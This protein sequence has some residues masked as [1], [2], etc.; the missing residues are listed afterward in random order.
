MSHAKNIKNYYREQEKKKQKETA[1]KRNRILMI[2][3]SVALLIAI[4]LTVVFC[5]V[6]KKDPI[7]VV[8]DVEKYGKITLEL[9]PDVAPI[10]V[11]NFVD[12]VEAGFYDGLT[13]HRVIE[14]FM[15][16]GGDPTG[17]GF[18]DSSLKTIKGEFKKNGVKNNLSFERGVIGMA[19]SNSY[20]SASSQFFI[21]H[22]NSTHLDGYYAA[23]GKVI[24]GL[25][26]VDAIATCDKTT[27]V[28]SEG[29]QY[30]PEEK[31]VIK[32][33]YVVE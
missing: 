12:Y 17:T 7:K 33:A 22:E 32:S 19:R 3:A 28:D 11:K 31:I 18:G 20:D 27:K 6:L 15:I 26:V 30:E 16:Q 25:T 29:T 14:G 23:F 21:C 2:V 8:I 13:F 24:D 5:F 10:T 9:Y 4:V 1:K